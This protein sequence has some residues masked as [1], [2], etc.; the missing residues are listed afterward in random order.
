MVHFKNHSTSL[1]RNRNADF[2]R[3]KQISRIFYAF[4]N[5]FTKKP[6]SKLKKNLKIKC[7]PIIFSTIHLHLPFVCIH[8]LHQ[9][10]YLTVSSHYLPK[11]SPGYCCKPVL[12]LYTSTPFTHT[13]KIPSDSAL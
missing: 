10:C 13:F 12:S 1:I 5:T 4:A 11:N 6:L 3:W 9:R 8:L 2:N 7:F